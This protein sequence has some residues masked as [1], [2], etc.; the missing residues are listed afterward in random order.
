MP[1][2]DY[3]VI[4]VES[5]PYAVKVRAVMRYRHIAYRWI[6]RMPQFL[7][8]TAEVRPLI[9][10]VVQFPDGSYRTDSTPIIRDLERLHSG[11]SLI[12]SDPTASFVADL[13]EDMADE[14][15]TKCLFQLRFSQPQDQLAGA[16][17]VMDDAHP[18]LTRAAYE[19]KV[20]EF[21]ERQVTRMPLV[22]CTAHNQAVIEAAY[23]ELLT[24]ME[25]FVA[26]DVFV[27]GSRPCLAD[28]GL[29]GQLSTLSRDP[30]ALAIMR[31]L[32]PRTLHWT[33]RIDDLSGVDGEWSHGL[34]P[35]A[36]EL[37]AYAVRWYLPYLAANHAAIENGDAEFA[38]EIN[39]L[40]YQQPVFRYHR[41]CFD[42][43]RHAYAGL[44][45]VAQRRLN[46]ELGDLS[47]L[48]D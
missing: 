1:Q 14:W 46:T 41:K 9:M 24:L 18:A 38:L 23:R 27:L 17:W 22:G 11:R 6:A 13:I 34:T 3:R 40:P 32:A 19:E 4:G 21:I 16:G 36:I 25:R 47:L 8:E 2:V 20:A 48:A 15:L 35:L 45:D 44:P 7:A 12:P 37:G 31:E 42:Y 26:T 43:L 33:R 10:P 29:Y 39:G 28:F 5:S 30:S